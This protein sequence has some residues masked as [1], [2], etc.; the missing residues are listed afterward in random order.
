[1]HTCS[2]KIEVQDLKNTNWCVS[3]AHDNMFAEIP[4]NDPIGLV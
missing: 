4:I 3:R 1:M 2:K